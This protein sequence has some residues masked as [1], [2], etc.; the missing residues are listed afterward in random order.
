MRPSM[1][2]VVAGLPRSWHTAPSITVTSCGRSRSPLRGARLVHH[3]QRV[4]PDVAFRVPLRLLRAADER[5]ELGQHA[6]DDAEVE[7]QRQADRRARGAWSSSFSI[8]PQMRSGGRSSSGM[9]RHRAAVASSRS[10]LEARRELHR[11]Q[12]AEAVVAEHPEIDGAQ[13]PAP[14]IAAA[15]EG[16]LVGVR[17]RIP[18]DRVDGEVAA[19]GGL[20]HRHER[21]AVHVEALVAA[22]ALRFPARQ[23]HVDG[24]AR[25]ADELVDGEAL[26]HGFDASERGEQ[27]RQPIL[28]ERRTPRR[29]DPSTATPRSR[30]RTHPPTTSARPPA[31]RTASASRTA[32]R[33]L[34]SLVL[35][36]A[37]A[38]QSVLY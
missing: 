12:H 36:F 11:A 38:T 37:S 9:R 27:R 20:G 4:H 23:R 14:Q 32:A 19:P 26:A 17:Q 30:S 31:S 13:D 21:V 28:R 29:R 8:S 10:K 6:R 25:E 33:T 15:V 24:S 16:I 1:T 3:H 34:S 22:A 18:P 2:A 7:R 35:P 5:H